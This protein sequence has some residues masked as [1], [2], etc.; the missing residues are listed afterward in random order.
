VV[1]LLQSPQRGKCH[2]GATSKEDLHPSEPIHHTGFQGL[3]TSKLVEA[4]GVIDHDPHPVWRSATLA[5]NVP[6]VHR[7]KLSRDAIAHRVGE[8]DDD[9][10]KPVTKSH[11]TQNINRI[12]ESDDVSAD[13]RD[14]CRGAT[15]A[16]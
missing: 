7:S 2:I 6:E 5:R 10:P 8:S 13:L 9:P 4:A 15:H 16:R 12:F 1:T 3:G 14:C 11:G